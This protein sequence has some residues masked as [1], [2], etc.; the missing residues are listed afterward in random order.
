MPTRVS[1]SADILGCIPGVGAGSATP[2]D[3]NNV[4]F[5]TLTNV[6]ETGTSPYTYTATAG[7][8]A[9]KAGVSNKSI[10]AATDGAFTCTL[11]ANYVNTQ[12]PVMGLAIANAAGAF[13]T[14]LA[15]MYPNPSSLFNY[16]AIENGAGNTGMNG[17]LFTP[18][19]SDQMR[20][21]RIGTV[22][23]AEVQNPA[24]VAGTGFW[25]S[26]HVYTTAAGV[27]QLFP[28][29]T[30]GFIGDNL[31]AGTCI[32]GAFPKWTAAGINLTH[33]GNSITRGQGATN[34]IH[35]LTACIARRTPY[36]GTGQPAIQ[37]LGVDGQTWRMMDGLDGGSSVDVDAAWTIGKTNVLVAWEGTNSLQG[38][39]TVLQAVADATSYI[40]NRQLV[41]SWDVRVIATA[42]PRGQADVASG[43]I[44]GMNALIDSWNTYI[45][46]NFLAMGF[47]HLIDVRTG[48]SPY[49]FNSYAPADFVAAASYYYQ[50]DGVSTH[51]NDLGYSCLSSIFSDAFNLILI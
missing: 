17:Y 47:T 41:H 10:A 25:H 38:G 26:M 27:A 6:A 33:D 14:W 34:A 44:A 35:N 42:M 9:A 13:A 37:N 5:S 21:R 23:V 18:A 12:Q 24:G 7:S 1:A 11:P 39:R 20:I 45:R 30:Y 15:G 19:A 50:T 32:S 29:S 40:T 22:F 2:P 48:N 49:N 31:I 36:V 16:K 4:R 46:A 43:T 28:Q 8:F 3:V 51:P